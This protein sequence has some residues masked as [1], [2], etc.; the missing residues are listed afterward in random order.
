MAEGYVLLHE[1]EAMRDG[2]RWHEREAR[3]GFHEVTKR[4]DDGTE[5]L[6]AMSF[7]VGA[8]G[9]GRRGRA[10]GV[11]QVDLAAAGLG[12]GGANAEV[13][14]EV[15][16]GPVGYVFQDATLLPWRTVLG[17]VE[18]LGQLKGVPKADRR[19]V[20]LAAIKTVGLSGFE[21]KYPRALSGGM[22]MRASLARALTMSP[23]VFLFDEPFGA[24]DEIT[25]Q[26]LNE[27]L[28]QL[29]Q[30]RLFAGLVRDPLSGR[31]S[32][33]GY[34]GPGDVGPSGG[35]SWPILRSPFGYPRS[36]RA[37]LFGRLRQAWLARS[38]L[39]PS[40]GS[41]LTAPVALDDP[42][43][44]LPGPLTAVPLTGKLLKHNG[45]GRAPPSAQHTRATVVRAG[46]LYSALWY[47]ASYLLL[48]PTR[49]FLLPPPQSVVSVGFV[50]L[51]QPGPDPDV[52]G[53]Y[54]EDGGIR[55]SFSPL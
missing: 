37:A 28:L 16:A 40:R 1:A 54:G 22:K 13:G 50:D 2:P 26:R 12:S 33:P 43:P 53:F 30:D 45:R 5:A 8:R 21:Q 25:R 35:A 3:L 27:E 11:R 39:G 49:R 31:G 47:G 15:A 14:V 9:T 55:A 48:S 34:A 24:L 36:A 10:V 41:L 6:R 52:S 17:N 23:N 32:V 19:Q 51:V 4:F 42:V 44:L 18:L 7:S 46:R 20:A 29:F 38:G